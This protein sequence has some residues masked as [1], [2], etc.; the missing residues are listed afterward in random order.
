MFP[1]RNV[2]LDHSATT[3]TDPRVVEAM[4]PYFSEIYGNP[5]SAHGFGRLAENGI[6]TARE[7]VARLLNSRPSEIVFTSGGSEADNLA[8]RGAAWSARQHG[9][10]NHVVTSPIEHDAVGKTVRQLDNVM[11][12]HTTILPVDRYGFVNK[13]DFDSA[14]RPGTTIASL[15]YANNEVGTIQPVPSLSAVARQHGFY[16]HTDAVQAAG[17]LSLDVQVLGVD[18]LSI[19]AHKFYGPK[20]VGAL[21]IREGIDL[22]PAQTG[23]SHEEGRRAGTHNTPLIVG[24]AKALEIAY[25]EYDH[26]TSHYRTM[27]DQL[28]DGVL[29]RV[30]GVQLTGHPEQRLSSHASF[31]LDGIESNALIMHLDARGIAA[32]ANSACKTGNPEP[33]EVL[34]AMG[35]SPKE[36]LGSLRLTVGRQTKPEDVDYAVE[37][38]AEVVEKLRTLKRELAL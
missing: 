19:S 21:Y 26:W 29:S 12:F 33:S 24:M 7:I 36:A 30:P 16:F 4:L 2:Y 13:T 32:S 17:Q 31:I 37:T 25:D 6:E 28:I 34:L 9:K 11:G 22:A 3:P 10:G 23:G 27:R 5:A 35:F 15:M 38:L 18:M 20:G 14:A 8:L 1:R